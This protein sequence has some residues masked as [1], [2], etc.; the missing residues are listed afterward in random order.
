MSRKSQV[1]NL[2]GLSTWSDGESSFRSFEL[3]GA[4]PHYSP[5][6]PGQVE[7]IFLDLAIDLENCQCQGTC[8]IRLTPIRDGIEHL[9][10]DAVEQT[11]AEV[12]IQGTPQPFDYDGQSL[13]IHLLNPLQQGKTIDLDIQYHLDRP[14]RGIYFIQPTATQPQKPV[15]VWTQGEDEDSRYWFPC[16]DYPGQL[17]TSEIRVRV[18][19]GFQA[20][21][22]GEMI[23]SQQEGEYHVYH[24]LQQQIHPTYLM[25]L[26]VG[27]FAEVKAQ[28]QGKPVL[29]YGEPGREADLKRTLGKTP[30]MM[31]VLSQ[32]FGYPYPYPHYTQVCVEDFI[33]G[34]MENTSTTLLTDRCLLDERAALDNRRSET[35]VAHEL[36]HQWFGDLVVIK[37]WA[38]AWIKEG[39]ATYSET[40]WVEHAYGKEEGAY[41]QLQTLRN[42]LDEDASR[43]RRPIVTHVYRE[44]I[45]LYDRHLYE[46]GACVYRL[47]HHEL[48][49]ELFWKSIQHFVQSHAHQTVETIDLIRA[50]ETTTGRNLL[51][52]FD[53]YVFRGGHPDYKVSYSWD[54][55]SHLAKVTVSQ[56]QADPKKKGKDCFDLKIGLAF[57]N[58]DHSTQTL[59][60]QH[61]VVRVHEV[62]QSFYFPLPQKPQ[63]LSFDPGNAILKTVELDYPV[64]ELKAQLQL[65]PDPVAR[66]FAAIALAKKGGLEAL[67]A[68]QQA[69]QEDPF[70]GVRAEV[71]QQIAELKLDQ[72]VTALVIGLGDTDPRVRRATV[73]ALAKLKTS[74]SYTALKALAEQGDPSYLVEADT[75]AAL[76]NFAD[77]GQNSHSKETEILDLLRQALTERSGWNEVVRAGAIR[78]ISGIKTS[79]A[80]L[81]LLLEYCEPTLP[82]P[83]RLAAI[84][85]LGT[86]ARGQPPSGVD[87]L[88]NHLEILSRETFFLTQVAV[89]VAL[90]KIA[91]PRAIAILH[92]LADQT[93]DGRVRLI[94]EEA[95]GT[96]Q[97]NLGSTKGIQTLRDDLETL[98]KENQELRSRLEEVEARL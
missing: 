62:E 68:L 40:L 80:A 94:A 98:R 25:T 26:V 61:F 6:R 22:N 20:I 83:L 37:H 8:H 53:Q 29:Y 11:I 95:I 97:A 54:Q 2:F 31:E 18:P 69:L 27:K 96:V 63:F 81:D 55:E 87:R 66:I 9:T 52:I 28:W 10:L 45:E 5:D 65:D 92:S 86:I 32:Y 7:H 15:Q 34:G 36:A 77:L 91:Q 46:K 19:Q 93:T 30:E 82:Q 49:D 89:V 60:P 38:H 78:G 56:Q 70:W 23:A 85:A 64:P 14:Q 3:P 17:A 79:S 75:L 73:N 57:Y 90:E 47:L 48:G 1:L 35:L 42:Y 21:A 67:K 12:S 58:Q 84:R 74:E 71:A 51:F 13:Q 43:Y 16:F 50:I 44:P 39:M 72:T 88:L 33:F 76:G 41:Y 4:K 59:A 24:W